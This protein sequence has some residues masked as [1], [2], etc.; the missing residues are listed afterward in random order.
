MNWEAIGEI[1]GAIGVIATIIFLAFQIR[2][3]STLLKNNT[4]QLEHSHEVALAEAQIQSTGSV[5]PMNEVA[6]SNELSNIMYK[7]FI[8][9]Q[10]LDK[11][12]SMR[13]SMAMGSIIAGVKTSI[14]MQRQLGVADDD[15]VPYTLNFA[16]RFIDTVGRAN[17]GCKQK[18]SFLSRSLELSIKNL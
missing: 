9:Y 4:R 7:G 1:V 18:T 5:G 13:F 15:H 14:M 6:Q 8:N 11:E 2:Q 10:E 17:G 3:N 16:M 12:S